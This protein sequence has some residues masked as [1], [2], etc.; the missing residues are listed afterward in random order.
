M[1][2]NERELR[3]DSFFNDM[4]LYHSNNT[5]LFD[6]TIFTT[7]I[8]RAPFIKQTLGKVLKVSA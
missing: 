1:K 5:V 2:G 6:L 7:S 3:L 8:K 4:Q